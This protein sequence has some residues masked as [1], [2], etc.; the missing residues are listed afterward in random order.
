MSKVTPFKHGLGWCVRSG[1][2]INRLGR[3]S[4][5]APGQWVIVKYVDVPVVL[6]DAFSAAFGPP[7]PIV[8]LFGPALGGTNQQSSSGGKELLP[9]VLSD[10]IDTSDSSESSGDDGESVVSDSSS[11]DSS[12]ACDCT[13]H[14]P[15]GGCP[16]HDPHSRVRHVREEEGRRAR[17]IRC[18]RGSSECPNSECE[19]WDDAVELGEPVELLPEGG[20]DA[21]DHRAASHA[22]ETSVGGKQGSVRAGGEGVSRKRSRVHAEGAA[23]RDVDEVDNC[24]EQP[25]SLPDDENETDPAFV[26]A[27]ELLARRHA[28]GLAR[29][30]AD[31]PNRHRKDSVRSS[32]APKR[33]RHSSCGPTQDG[34]AREG[35]HV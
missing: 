18:G 15:D 9:D 34:G 4:A 28:R 10:S 13:A 33:P 31:W 16:V 2:L 29:S 22:E 25:A 23:V 35:D 20:R 27:R 1:S 30:A 12:A 14:G 5:L 19:C 6:L 11:G 24:G 32:P 8:G 3:F 21:V 26:S 7:S 17:S